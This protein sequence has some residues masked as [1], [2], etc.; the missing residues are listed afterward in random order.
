MRSL[1]KQSIPSCCEV[2]CDV[3]LVFY[4]TLITFESY[5]CFTVILYNN[6]KEDIVSVSKPSFS[7]SFTY[8]NDVNTLF[9]FN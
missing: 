3:T 5:L 9:D 8:W 1:R 4:K 2:Y 6:F 7:L